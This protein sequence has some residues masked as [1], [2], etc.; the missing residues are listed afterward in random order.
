MHWR[1]CQGR[2]G[3]LICRG[4]GNSIAKIAAMVYNKNG[5][6]QVPNALFLI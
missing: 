6:D 3:K 1:V 4:K 5:Y 2:Y